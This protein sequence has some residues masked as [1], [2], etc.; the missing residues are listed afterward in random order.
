MAIALDALLVLD[1]IE[2][3]GSFAAAAAELHRVPSAITYAVRKLEDELDVLL[4]DRRGHRAELTAAGRELVTAGRRL[5]AAAGELEHRVRRIATGWEPELR[6]AVDTAVPFAAVWPLVA[7]FYA[8]CNTRQA[9]HTRLRL[10]TE[11]LGGGW[12]ALADGRADIALG[13]SGDPP[14]PG[15]RLRPLAELGVVFAVAPG[16]PLAVHRGP[17]PEATIERH[18]AIVAADSSRRLPARTIG[19]IAGQDTLTVPDMPAKVAAQVAGLGCG[20]LPQHLAAPEVAAGRLVVKPVVAP[21]PPIALGVAWRAERTGRALAWWIDAASRRGLGEWLAARAGRPVAAAETGGR[22]T[23]AR[24][25]RPA[26]PKRAP[27]G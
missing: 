3:R 23:S 26:P 22:V 9:A 11:V 5:L 16:H 20:F 6:V 8:D 14:G 25:R 4:F 12:D 13:V 7:D 1:A 10:S 15:Y 27:R 18:R 17:I 21:L 24:S 19:L 2:R